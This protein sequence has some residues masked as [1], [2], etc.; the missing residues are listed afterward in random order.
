MS[1]QHEASSLNGDNGFPA[2][3]GIVHDAEGFRLEIA[4][5][6]HPITGST[7]EF[8]S[9][10]PKANHPE[11][12]R[13]L[14]LT[15]PAESLKCIAGMMEDAASKLEATPGRHSLLEIDRPS[16]LDPCRKLPGTCV[17]PRA[18]VTCMHKKN[19]RTGVT[20]GHE[21]CDL[22]REEFPSVC[23]MFKR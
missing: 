10:W 14:S 13:L 23:E 19:R 3:R 6:H 8:F 4:I 1:H 16:L 15:L 18:C 9:T 5:T 20:I 17:I 7:V 21:R 11:P 22:G 2:T 12:H